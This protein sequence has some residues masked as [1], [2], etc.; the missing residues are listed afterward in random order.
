MG[1]ACGTINCK[2][3]KHSKYPNATIIR[4][5]QKLDLSMDEEV[6]N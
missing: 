2:G 5:P 6:E 1:A 4:R 3:K